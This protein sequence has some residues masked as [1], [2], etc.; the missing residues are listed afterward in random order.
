[1]PVANHELTALRQVWKLLRRIHIHPGYFIIP[2][3]LSIVAAALEGVSLS[4]LIP[5]VNGFFNDQD[6]SFVTGV[7][8][9]GTILKYL[10]ASITGSDRMLFGTLLGIFVLV[11]FL[12]NVTR[13]LATVT[14]SY[15]SNRAI[16]HLRKHVFDSYLS[17]G[18]LYF[19]KTNVGHHATLLSQFTTYALAPLV[20]IDKFFQ[21]VLSL[22]AYGVVM[23]L[24]SWQ[25]TLLALP[26]FLILHFMVRSL[27]KTIQ[28]QSHA[29]TQKANELG[30]NVVEILSV[31]PLVKAYNT[32]RQEREHYTLISDEAAKLEFN[33]TKV[34]ELI[35]PLQ[36][37]VTL[38]AMSV[39]FV[40]MLYFIVYEKSVTPS[41]F[42]VL[43]YLIMNATNKFSVLTSFRGDL[44]NAAGPLK[45]V[46]E[47]F[48]AEGKHRI[49]E[50]DRVFSGLK[51]QIEYRNVRFGYAPDRQILKG[52]SMG[53]E[54]GKVTAIVGPTGAGK[55]TVTSLLLRYYDCEPG[56]IFLDGTDI[57]DFQTS[58][59]LKNMA[60]VSQDTLLLHDTLRANITY[61]LEDVPEQKLQ[62]VI[63]RARL[64]DYVGQLPHGLDTLIGD[65][66]TKLSGGEKQRVSI[67]RALLKNA[68]ILILDEATSS[69]D[70]KTEK[71]IQEAIE[72]AIVGRT[73]IVI[74]HRLS[75][76]RN[77]DM[78][79]VI[80]DGKCAEEGSFDELLAKK[81]KFSEY[82]TEQKF[83]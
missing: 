65:R 62:E 15:M 71:L 53:I 49:P 41:S 50:G 82:W 18:K 4:L 2:V 32:E 38:I 31:I 5:L 74:A 22:V 75:T 40:I 37:G 19:D 69:L 44:A 39:L 55:T 78:I 7:P 58:S 64:K 43:L 80:E 83:A 73:A 8:V 51:Q 47:V 61:G 67:A 1:M 28:R 16:H 70:S 60:L 77:A 24:L 30:K 10:P 27:I 17:F 57:R 9:L 20:L 81:G 59:L 45:A 34:K 52:L 11:I 29:L 63:E 35:R 79:V 66:G 33:K 13:Y 12:K 25:L 46:L 68:S 23:F 6:F 26:L 76:I 72:E 48:D 54:K 56:S 42:I 3:S 14:M 36:E 21:A